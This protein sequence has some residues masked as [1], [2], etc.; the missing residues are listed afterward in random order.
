[1]LGGGDSA[2]GRS[3]ATH[4]GAKDRVPNRG[5]ALLAR[6]ST[7]RCN[8]TSDLEPAVMLASGIIMEARCG[9]SFL[10]K[11]GALYC[12]SQGKVLERGPAAGPI[13]EGAQT[14]PTAAMHG[15]WGTIATRRDRQRCAACIEIGVDLNKWETNQRPSCR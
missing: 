7:V 13:V 15:L 14:S 9:P 10:C 5:R 8:L 11:S 2:W 4:R 1:V 3:E 6:L 12:G